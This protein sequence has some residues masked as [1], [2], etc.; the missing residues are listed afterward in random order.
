MY[1]RGY[2]CAIIG[3]GRDRVTIV[4]KSYGADAAWRSD[5]LLL[6][7]VALLCRGV[8]MYIVANDLYFRLNATLLFEKF[9]T[10]FELP[11]ISIE[12]GGG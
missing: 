11:E 10:L 7:L 2:V 6:L 9:M 8:H 3:F 12:T 1:M 5:G 4:I